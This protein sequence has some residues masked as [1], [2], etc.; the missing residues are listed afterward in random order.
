MPPLISWYFPA[1]TPLSS[2]KKVYTC[3]YLYTIFNSLPHLIRDIVF[4][5]I[6]C[7]YLGAEDDSEFETEMTRQWEK[8]SQI[9]QCHL[10]P[11]LPQ[12][13]WCPPLV[14]QF[15]SLLLQFQ[16]WR[17]ARGCWNLKPQAVVNV[18]VFQSPCFQASAQAQSRNHS[19]EKPLRKKFKEP[20]LCSYAPKPLRLENTTSIQTRSYFFFKSLTPLHRPI[21]RFLELATPDCQTIWLRE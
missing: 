5:H 13:A 17:R 4:T 19:E 7:C 8:W 18:L 14:L 3:I 20:Y 2:L 10:I 16:T 9:E 1:N 12:D 21:C 15:W 6:P 11:K